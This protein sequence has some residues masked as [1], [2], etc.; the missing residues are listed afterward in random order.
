MID[1]GIITHLIRYLNCDENPLPQSET[2]SALV[3]VIGFGTSDHRRYLIAAGVIPILI[4]LLS[5]SNEIVRAEAAG[6]LANIANADVDSRDIVLAAG[7]LPA[8]IQSNYISTNISTI[9]RITFAISNLFFVAPLPDLELVRAA[10]PLLCDRLLLSQDDKTV[11][12]ACYGLCSISEGS[13]EYIQAILGLNRPVIP[14][15]MEL[16]G[17]TTVEVIRP[18]LLSIGYIGRKDPST[19]KV[20]QQHNIFKLLLDLLDHPIDGI[21]DDTCWVLANITES[22]STEQIQEVIDAAIIPKLFQLLK[23]SNLGSDIQVLTIPL[24]TKIL[25]YGTPEQVCYFVQEG[26]IPL[27]CGFLKQEGDMNVVQGND[28]EN[29]DHN[30]DLLMKG[31]KDIIKKLLGEHEVEKLEDAMHSIYDFGGINIINQLLSQADDEVDS[32]VRKVLTNFIHQAN[33]TSKDLQ[34]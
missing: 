22:K 16:S 24:I 2:A 14:R 20:L 28:E 31:L 4:R 10:L 15:L 17:H 11:S 8:L 32:D 21:R 3:Q 29:V 9:Q 18:A 25:R 5:S 23:L 7:A 13:N 27:F 12:V 30:F 1:S 33:V 6:S 34:K 19:K 26:I